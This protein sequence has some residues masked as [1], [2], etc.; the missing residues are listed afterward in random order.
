MTCM[1]A[2]PNIGEPY[3]GRLEGIK[4]SCDEGSY[5]SQS[6]S[7]KCRILTNFLKEAR[8]QETLE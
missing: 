8:Y 4:K 7:K 6:H 5:I 1:H 2:S 3:K